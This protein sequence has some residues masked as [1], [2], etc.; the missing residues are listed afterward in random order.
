MTE[1]R[2]LKKECSIC[3]HLIIPAPYPSTHYGK[4]TKCKLKGEINVENQ[5]CDDFE[6]SS[7]Y[8]KFLKLHD[9]VLIE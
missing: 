9:G 7:F 2:Y 4:P 8:L 5:C 3:K 6:L 1:K